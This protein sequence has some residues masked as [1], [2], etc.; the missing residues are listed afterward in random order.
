MI[1]DEPFSLMYYDDITLL[2]LI[3]DDSNTFVQLS[4]C[5][6]LGHTQIF[7]CTACG[8]GS[9]VWQGSALLIECPSTEFHLRH[10]QFS[11]SQAYKECNDGAIIARSV[12]S[13]GQCYTSML[14]VTVGQEMVNQTIECVYNN[15]ATETIINQITV[16]LTQGI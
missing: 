2:I 16:R 5:T 12:G 9:T 3:G 15:L 10:S 11:N 13:Q 7:E 8:P 6:C 4:D 1:Y 14:S